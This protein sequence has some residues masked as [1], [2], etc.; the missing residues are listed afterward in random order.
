M[1]PIVRVSS[2]PPW[3]HYNKDLTFAQGS[4]ILKK[5]NDDL[6]SAAKGKMKQEIDKATSTADQMTL[7]QR[8][9]KMVYLVL[10][11]PPGGMST[12][13]VTKGS[14]L[15]VEVTSEGTRALGESTAKSISAGASAV[16]L[17]V[18]LG[19]GGAS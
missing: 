19:G 16:N 10:R 8:L 6:A 3:R 15:S 12:T 14:T 4:N 9:E 18:D 11:D 5:V 1:E 2:E 17:A 7:M 13:S